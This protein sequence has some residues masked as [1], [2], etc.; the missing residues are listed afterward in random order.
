[1]T[2]LHDNNARLHAE[3]E[4]GPQ[5]QKLQEERIR[6][7]E[8][9]IEDA[10]SIAEMEGRDFCLEPWASLRDAVKSSEQD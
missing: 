4:D 1:M 2:E 7:L 8:T 6:D 5:I 10:L 9:A 3:L